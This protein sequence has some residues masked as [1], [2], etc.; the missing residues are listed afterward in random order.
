VPVPYVMVWAVLKDRTGN[1]TSPPSRHTEEDGS[2]DIGPFVMKIGVNPVSEVTVHTWDRSY[3]GVFNWLGGTQGATGEEVLIIGQGSLRRVKFSNWGLM[4]PASIF[5]AS[6]GVA[7]LGRGTRWAYKS[8]MALAFLLTGVM[9][10]AIS[11]GLSYVHTTGDKNEV[12]SLGFASLFRGQYVRQ[13]EPEWLFSLTAP[14]GL[15]RSAT[16]A[17]VN[18]AKAPDPKA[19]APALP[20]HPGGEEAPILPNPGKPPDA[21]AR[22]SALD[23]NAGSDEKREPLLVHGFGAPLWVLLLAVIGVAL[24][25]MSIIVSEISHEPDFND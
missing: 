22:S 1:R 10:I 14:H 2:F 5:L 15:F 24:R 20:A 23:A 12:L 25:T 19:K 3:T 13:A 4:V 18:P 8:A 11:A 7:F 16:E 17:P 9:I 6:M 21:K